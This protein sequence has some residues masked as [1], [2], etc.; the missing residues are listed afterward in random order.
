[1]AVAQVTGERLDDR[2]GERTNQQDAAVWTDHA[3]EAD[4][5]GMAWPAGD[6]MTKYRDV[7]LNQGE[8]QEKRALTPSA[9]KCL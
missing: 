8:R 4:D 3:P 9:P 2:R 7:P 1:M 5:W 6:R